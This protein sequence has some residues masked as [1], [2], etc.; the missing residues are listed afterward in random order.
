MA[1]DLG[2]QSTVALRKAEQADLRTLKRLIKEE[3]ARRSAVGLEQAINERN[4]AS[5]A[6]RY[7]LNAV[8]AYRC[9]TMEEHRTKAEF[10]KEFATGKYGDLQ[11]EDVDALLWSFLP[12]EALE[13]AVKPSE[14]GAA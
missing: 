4:E 14:S 5:D 12:E 2:K 3:R 10:L 1:P 13:H 11:P 7:A 8:C 9:T 6:E